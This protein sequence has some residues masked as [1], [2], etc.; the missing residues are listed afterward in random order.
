MKSY[1]LTG[2]RVG[3]MIAIGVLLTALWLV[4]AYG[5]YMES[6]REKYDIHVSPG[7]V[8]YGTHST[9]TVPMVSV[10]RRQS[11]PM[12]SGGEVRS[13]AHQG[14][15]SMPSAASS[16]NG[17]YTTS[18]ATVKNIGSGITDI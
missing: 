18:S 17:L 16:A 9:A 7:A 14:H 11:L 6:Q 3:M 8:S 1:K 5:T 4:A 2:S 13:Y 12:I 15:A 10:S